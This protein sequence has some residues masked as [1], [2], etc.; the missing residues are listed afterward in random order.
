MSAVNV[1][2]FQ[3]VSRETSLF[4]FVTVIAFIIIIII[5]VV[6]HA[7]VVLSGVATDSKVDGLVVVIVIVV[8]VNAVVATRL[9]IGLVDDM[10][11]DGGC[12]VPVFTSFGGVATHTVSKPVS[13]RLTMSISASVVFV[14][15]IVVIVAPCTNANSHRNGDG[16]VY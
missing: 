13:L 9:V 7:L 12:P 11:P 8:N 1:E 3:S 5:T 15:V 2:A 16:F 10:P 14:V 6:I 4:V